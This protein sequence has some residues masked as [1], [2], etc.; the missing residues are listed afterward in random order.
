MSIPLE[1][2]STRSIKQPISRM[3]DQAL[4]CV[5]DGVVIMHTYQGILC[6]LNCGIVDVKG[7]GRQVEQWNDFNSRVDELHIL[8]M[9][10]SS[11]TRLAILHQVCISFNSSLLSR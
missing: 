6:F 8:D 4:S 7:K 5:F 2:K 9:V 10:M 1:T 3:A 11:R